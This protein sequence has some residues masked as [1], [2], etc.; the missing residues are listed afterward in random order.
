MTHLDDLK[1]SFEGKLDQRA[2]QYKTR[3]EAD[4]QALREPYRRQIQ[5][6]LPEDVARRLAGSDQRLRAQQSAARQSLGIAQPLLNLQGNDTLAALD[7]AFV[8][9][10]DLGRYYPLHKLEYPIVYCESLEEFFTPVVAHLNLS[11]QARQ[12]ALQAMAAEAQAQAKKYQ[13]GGTFGY[14]LSGLGCYLNGWLFAYNTQLSPGQVFESAERLPRILGTAIHE[15]LGHGF[16]DVYSALGEVKSQLGVTLAETARRFG[17]QAADNPLDSL[18]SDQAVLLNTASLLVEE[19]WATWIESFLPSQI[20]SEAE[21]RHYLIENVIQ[22]IQALPEEIPNRSDLQGYL[23]GA[24]ALLFSDEDIPAQLL[25]EAALVIHF[26]GGKY[27]PY[28]GDALGQPLRYVIGDLLMVQAE[29]NLGPL[30]LPYAALIAAN[31]NFDP[32]GI[33]LSDL[34]EMLFTK[35]QL[36]P[37]ARLAA[38]S[39][40]RLQQPNSVAELLQR[41]EAELSFIAPQELK[42]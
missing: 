18:R 10:F 14:N 22:A 34:R 41:A 24:L 17:Y 8:S 39:R 35:P 36:N 33:S 28:F 19:G 21:A 29:G 16:L 40:L 7:R 42:K 38:L 3:L 23:L 26:E 30:C 9:A 31:I 37:D 27:D 4:L 32:Q 6:A 1:S 2:M 5:P 12:T 15:K 13:G 11:P 20:F 25:L